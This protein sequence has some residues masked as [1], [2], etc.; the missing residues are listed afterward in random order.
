[1]PITG[2]QSTAQILAAQAA[3]NRKLAEQAQIAAPERSNLTGSNPL[4][5]ISSGLNQAANSL[6]AP[7]RRAALDAEAA[8]QNAIRLEQQAYSRGQTEDNTTYKRNQDALANTRAAESAKAS[9]LIR[10]NEE[11]RKQVAFENE[12]QDRNAQ[13]KLQQAQAVEPELLAEVDSRELQELHQKGIDPTTGEFQMINEI[14]LYDAKREKGDKFDAAREFFTNIPGDLSKNSDAY[15]KFTGD[16][17]DVLARAK[18]R[19]NKGTVSTKKVDRHGRPLNK[20]SP[21]A[22]GGWSR[23]YEQLAIERALRGTTIGS[24]YLSIDGD[25]Q[26][27]AGFEDR[28]VDEMAYIMDNLGAAKQFQ[29]IKAPYDNERKKIKANTLKQGV[30]QLR[31][32]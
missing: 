21:E 23:A 22:K 20:T 32:K 25:L 2:T 26:D 15:D 7:D 13:I 17:S 5:L 14:S 1:M 27:E 4:S 6:T 11:G 16:V 19:A 31:Q 28:L 24:G 12:I 18:T 3:N 9:N 29:E 8:R 30:R 10:A